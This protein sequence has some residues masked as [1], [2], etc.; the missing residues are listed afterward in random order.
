MREVEED[1]GGQVTAGGVAP[2]VDPLISL[3][4]GDG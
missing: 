4:A 2:M 3:G 1:G